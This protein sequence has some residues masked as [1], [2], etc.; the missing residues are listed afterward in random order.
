MGFE[1]EGMMM[2]PLNAPEPGTKM[3]VKG[4]GNWSES[5]SG[6][7]EE[8]VGEGIGE[9][10][11]GLQMALQKGEERQD[12]GSVLETRTWEVFFPMGFHEM[13]HV[14]MRDFTGLRWRRL[15]RVDVWADFG[16]DSLDWEFCIDDL[17]VVFGGEAGDS[18]GRAEHDTIKAKEKG[19]GATVFP[20][21][22]HGW[23]ESQAYLD[24]N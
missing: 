24:G 14:R 10:S 11:F 4:V 17:A 21:Q 1:L 23:Q 16:Y 20:S 7:K 6:I 5:E 12:D 13:L 8:N 15:V 18:A 22:Q 3:F 2:K 19:K 9:R